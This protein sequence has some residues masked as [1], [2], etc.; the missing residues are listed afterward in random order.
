MKTKEIKTEIHK[1]I[2]TI[3]DN[4][5]Q[6]ILDYLKQLQDISQ[7]KVELSKNLKLI[8]TEDRELLKKLAH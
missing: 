8:L 6:D 3:P 1:V 2:D 7:S 5:L 4:V